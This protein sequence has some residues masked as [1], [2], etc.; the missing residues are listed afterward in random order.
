MISRKRILFMDLKTPLTVVLIVSSST[1]T[2][3]FLA[4]CLLF[5][6][7]FNN[8]QTEI[9]K[10]NLIISHGNYVINKLEN[11]EKRASLA[12]KEASIA[13]NKADIAAKTA[14]LAAK[15]IES[16]R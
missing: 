2:I 9:D 10:M 14:A 3:F 11:I 12:D 7:A 8:Q 16:K 6:F 1:A 15:K 4:V 5:S 13:A